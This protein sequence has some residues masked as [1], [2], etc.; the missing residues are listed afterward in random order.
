MINDKLS[1]QIKRH[2]GAV[3]LSNGRHKVYRCPAGH[4]TVGWGRNL[5]GR[6]LSDAEAEMLLRND[7]KE[8]REELLKTWP[9]MQSLDP[10]R[11]SAFINLHFNMG[12]P[13]L[14]QFIKTLDAAKK[15]DWHQCADE[16][17]DSRWYTQVGI[18]GK[19]IVEQIHYGK[20][21]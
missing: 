20:W 2:E 12:L 11:L 3:T 10:I 6:G 5:E 18:R 15:G 7:L 8:S 21:L 1:E 17:T 16:L 9:W 19:E 14:K 4:L 13:T